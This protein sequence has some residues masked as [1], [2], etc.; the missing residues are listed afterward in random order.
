MT[1]FMTAIRPS[2]DPLIDPLLAEYVKRTRRYSSIESMHHR[3]EAA[4]V[5]WLARERASKSTFVTLLD[6][7]GKLLSSEKFAAQIDQVRTSGRRQ[8]VLAI[9]PPDGWD[10]GTLKLADSL[11]S[12][13]PMTLP[14]QLARLVLAEQ[15]YRAFTILAGHP[16]HSGH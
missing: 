12:L 13:G 7:R 5:E 14:H 9:G 6:S 1:L 8:M 11:L 15:V 10:A 2:T 4:F 3:S 16:Y